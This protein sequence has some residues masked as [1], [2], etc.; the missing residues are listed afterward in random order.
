MLY[1]R[2]S[3]TEILERF[4]GI[5]N[6]FKLNLNVDVDV[7]HCFHQIYEL[8]FLHFNIFPSTSLPRYTKWVPKY[9]SILLFISDIHA[10]TLSLLQDSPIII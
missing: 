9:Q 10:W 6:F 4:F 3:K 8:M 7:A 5:D 1:C 2:F